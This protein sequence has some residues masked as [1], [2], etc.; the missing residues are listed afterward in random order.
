MNPCSN[1]NGPQ[2]QSAEHRSICW[3][4]LW[5]DDPTVVVG[6]N[7]EKITAIIG[8]EEMESPKTFLRSRSGIDDDGKNEEEPNPEEVCLGSVLM[9]IPLNPATHSGANLPP[10]ECVQPRVSQHRVPAGLSSI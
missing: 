6:Y 7:G 9:G 8:H 2:D 1:G 10:G 3:R 5:I 4:P